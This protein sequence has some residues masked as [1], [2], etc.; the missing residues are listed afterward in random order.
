MI[1]SNYKGKSR[2]TAMLI[3]KK[4]GG[5]S[6]AAQPYIFR[7]TQTD[8]KEREHG[9]IMKKIFSAA[10]AA[11][12]LLSCSM[13]PAYAANDTTAE[14]LVNGGFEE[15]LLGT[16]GW[17]FS[18]RGGWYNE[19]GA[20]RSADEMHN[21]TYSLALND[22][23][24]GQR[25][26]LEAEKTYRLS[27]FYKA[28]A[29][30]S[31]P[32]VKFADGTAEWPASSAIA[33][34]SLS[35][36]TE[37]QK[38]LLELEST[39]SQDYVIC[40]E[41]WTGGTT[42]YF[43]DVSLY[44]YVPP[45]DGGGVANGDFSN[46]LESWT[47]DGAGAVTDG[48]FTVSGGDY[49]MRLSQT[50]EGLE[51]GVYDLTAYAS[52]S[53]I[54]GIAYLY[55]K[56]EGHTMASTSVPARNGEAQ[57]VVVPGIIV[58]NGSCDIGLY[59]E[60]SSSIT[61]DNISFSASEETRVPFLKGGEI[62][63][64]TY[65]EDMGGKFYYADGTEGDALQ[66]MAENGFNLARIRLLDDPGKGHGDGTY[67]LPEGY[68]DLEDCLELS[69]RAKDKG[70]QI[71][72]TF[73]YSDYWVD[74]EKQMVPAAWQQEITEQGLSGESLVQYLE[75]KVYTYT[76][77]VMEKL[78]AQGTCPE[79]VSIGNEVQVG[80]LFNR[81]RPNN[82]LYN[83]SAYLARLLSSGAQAVRDTSPESKIIFHSDNGG[84]LYRR[85][86][87]I[88]ALRTIDSSLYDVIG[89]SY[90]PFY[91]STLADSDN[92]PFSADTVV[93]DF[94]RVINEFDKD[95]I[96]MET[97]Y[98]WAE[99]RGDGYE[100]QL[101]DS[102]YYQD[103]Y[104]ETQDGQRAFLT[105][106]YSKLKQTL[107]GRCIG[108]MYWDPVMIYD[109]GTYTIG[110][111]IEENGDWTQGN[112]V[113]NSTI[114][115]FDGKEVAGQQAMRYN[116]NS[117]DNILITG[118]AGSSGDTLANTE[119][120]FTV[121][122]TPYTVTTDKF[123][124]YIVSVP[125]PSDGLLEISANGSET[126]YHKDAPY[127]GV[128]VRDVDFDDIRLNYISDVAV[129]ADENGTISYSA[130]FGTDDP[131]AVFFAMLYNEN[132]EMKGCKIDQESGSFTASDGNGQYTIKLFL[133]DDRMVPLCSP[134]SEQVIYN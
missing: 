100:G 79:Y 91:S 85:G 92:T 31:A 93:N 23:T 63:K 57:K 59:A 5:S 134:H 117:T 114:F 76:K 84:N 36:T 13:L 44:E 109:G 49:T 123:G 127:D 77:D 46:G 28:D 129:S 3:Y 95:V 121:N 47:L 11:V 51:N 58:E 42:V 41:G 110:W 112:V 71:C 53:D 34:A 87:F 133:W 128:L 103:I 74:A 75:D 12:M 25:V 126:T 66:I 52:S 17:H 119:I 80:I 96:I 20:E 72:F 64:L 29:A 65:V 10:L 118:T 16:G 99:L 27:F 39:S 8:F 106:L 33:S 68:M 73:A 21:G 55:G 14:L 22:G 2:N 83:N 120:T 122:D 94:A 98:N 67:Y 26:A 56:T 18:D 115:D 62:S 107:G 89:V 40:L 30:T 131:E 113:S 130:D 1:Q 90:Y 82:G 97:G 101:Q 48:A 69:R 43:D 105:E 102:G 50:V 108:D 86:T 132:G 24:A 78:M 60:G 70:M 45:Y 81:Q 88:S 35:A 125:Y 38:G 104:G 6:I 111:A 4:R 7:K 15:V 9:D 124:Q 54:S 37:W 32:V 61:L 19:D 116:T